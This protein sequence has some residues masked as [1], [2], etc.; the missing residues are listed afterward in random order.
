M[1]I[2]LYLLGHKLY[3]KLVLFLGKL[4]ND[5]PLSAIFLSSMKIRNLRMKYIVNEINGFKWF[6][7]NQLIQ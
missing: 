2:K 1:T 4:D 7:L 6:D 5:F 3:R